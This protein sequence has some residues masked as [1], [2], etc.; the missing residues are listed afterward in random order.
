MSLSHLVKASDTKV[1]GYT[2]LRKPAG[3]IGLTIIF[4][5]YLI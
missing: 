2:Y 4:R 1:V 3:K 5:S